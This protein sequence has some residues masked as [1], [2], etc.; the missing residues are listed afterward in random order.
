MQEN[1]ERHQTTSNIIGFVAVGINGLALILTIIFFSVNIKGINASVDA[2]KYADSTFKIY[3]TI[4][5]ETRRQFGI[6]NDPF[7][8]VDSINIE[9]IKA[10]FPIVVYF[11]INNIKSVATKVN[12]N[13]MATSVDSLEIPRKNLIDTFNKYADHRKFY[14][15]NKY[16]TQLQPMKL[17]SPTSFRMNQQACDSLY[18]NK[19]FIYL[20]GLCDYENLITK[21]TK[22]YLYQIKIT[23]R[24]KGKAINWDFIYNENLDS[25]K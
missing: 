13:L 4:L 25:L 12:D 24:N 10:G 14:L 15:V 17:V 3:D 1:N 11:T 6:L 21:T 20:C 22:Y 5:Q 19:T 2:S 23:V 9:Q 7:I 8:Q 16:I 18:A